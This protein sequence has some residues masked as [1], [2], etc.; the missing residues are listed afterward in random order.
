MPICQHGGIDYAE[1]E[2]LG[3]APQDILDFSANLNPFGPP[4]EVMEA[5]RQVD[6]SH[7]PDPE[8]RYLRH[9]P[10]RKAKNKQR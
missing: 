1:V 2:M 10:G 9:F 3:I 8:A 5:L 4:P 6:I 7:Y